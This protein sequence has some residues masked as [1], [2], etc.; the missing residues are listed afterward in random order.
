[1]DDNLQKILEKHI[2]KNNIKKSL[3]DKIVLYYLIILIRNV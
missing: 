3:Y 1:M 2:D